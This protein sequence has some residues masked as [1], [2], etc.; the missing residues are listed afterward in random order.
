MNSIRIEL[1]RYQANVS[2]DMAGVQQE[3]QDLREVVG[4]GW[5]GEE[6][7]DVGEL[8]QLEEMRGL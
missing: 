1:Q 3:L 8:H 7:R 5:A 6:R 4:A 2:A